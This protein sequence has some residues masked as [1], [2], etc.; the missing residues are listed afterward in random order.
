MLN[1]YFQDPYLF[2]HFRVDPNKYD[3]KGSKDNDGITP[4]NGFDGGD[5]DDVSSDDLQVVQA[6]NLKSSKEPFLLLDSWVYSM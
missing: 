1:G 4:N 6:Y 3:N 5:D 2:V